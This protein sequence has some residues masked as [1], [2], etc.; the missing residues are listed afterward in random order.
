[1]TYET[2]FVK[3]IPAKFEHGILYIVQNEKGENETC[4]FLCPKPECKINVNR[5]GLEFWNKVIWGEMTPEPRSGMLGG[6]TLM[7]NTDN[8]PT[9]EPSF[10]INEVC[11]CDCHFYMRNGE[12]EYV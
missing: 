3:K 4:Y 10:G 11:E 8:K 2:K 6:W 9:L 5:K 7:D 12:L 1:M